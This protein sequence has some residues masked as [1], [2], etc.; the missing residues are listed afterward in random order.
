M[1]DERSGLQRNEEA[2][3]ECLVRVDAVAGWGMRSGVLMN[4]GWVWMTMRRAVH[5][6][7]AGLWP[8][9]LIIIYS[10]AGPAGPVFHFLKTSR[11]E[12]IFKILILKCDFQ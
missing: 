3:E 11:L 7:A 6:P 10:W 1:A 8:R 2:S 12:E 5:V 9:T 4:L